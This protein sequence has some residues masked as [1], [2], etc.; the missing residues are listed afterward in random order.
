MSKNKSYKTSIFKVILGVIGLFVIITI[1]FGLFIGSSENKD[2]TTNLINNDE[3]NI[4]SIV[5][6]SKLDNNYNNLK[7]G[8][9]FII[10]NFEITIDDIKFVKNIYESKESFYYLESSN[11]EV[12]VILDIFVTNISEQTNI[13]YL[14]NMELIDKSGYTYDQQWIDNSSLKNA[15]SSYEE[16][17]SNITKKGRIL[18][19]IYSDINTLSDLKLIISYDNWFISDES[20]I[21]D[22]F[23]DDDIWFSTT[24]KIKPNINLDFIVEKVSS[25]WTSYN[26]PY[27][28][29]YGTINEI[30]FDISNNSG[31]P[32][33][34]LKIE[35]VIENESIDYISDFT[36]SYPFD[37]DI[38]ENI[39]KE[40]YMF[41][42]NLNSRKYFKL[43]ANVVYD[44]EIIDSITYNFDIK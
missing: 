12:Y 14:G 28:D 9:S 8:K 24:D 27:L 39:Q 40:I 31:Y 18:F 21:V 2:T 20:I 6:S 41:E 34:N 25:K 32:L 30:I 3:N 10:N 4:N 1:I 17:P 7:I 33:N 37:L 13:F 5:E 26:S 42:T 19:K 35:G 43:I 16:I 36:T 38:N 15:M 23:K 22:I 44:K 29:N 11:D